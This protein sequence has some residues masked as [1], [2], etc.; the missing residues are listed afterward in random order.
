M[1]SNQTLVSIGQFDFKL[2]H[3]LV[4]AILSLSFSIS[5]LIR[6]QPADYGWELNEFDPFFNYRATE[7]VLEN[8]IEKYFAWNDELSWYPNGRDVSLNSQVVLHLFAALTYQIFGNGNLYD[9]TILFPAVI[10]SLTSVV[11]FAFVRVIGGTTAGLFSAMFFSIS[12][13]VILRGSLGWFKSEPLGLFLGI[14]SLYLFLSGIHSKNKKIA[15]IKLISAGILIV[16]GTSA[17]GGIQFFIIPLG[18]F[19]LALPFLRKDHKFLL[20]A[21]PTF[22]ISLTITSLGFERLG[23]NFVSG[24]GGLSLII[25]TIFLLVCILIQNKSNEKNKTRNGLFLLATLLIISSSLLIVNIDSNFLPLPS[26]RYLNAINPFLTTTDPLVDSVSE[27]ATTTIEQS[28]LFHS[29]LMI[30]ASIGIWLL[31]KNL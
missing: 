8:G 16:L 3:L 1:N 24:L 17:W 2:N 10:G 19:F 9:F 6:A 5:F 25:P 23:T 30:F 29:V 11:V 4:I 26:F 14:L 7:Y 13:P 12:L 20:W 21:I 28:F 31:F 27:H 22:T 18:I 15:F